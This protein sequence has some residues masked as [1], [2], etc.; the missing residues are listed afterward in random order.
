[1]FIVEAEVRHVLVDACIGSICILILVFSLVPSRRDDLEA[2]ALMFIHLLTPHGLP[3]TRNG[4]PRTDSEHNRLKSA[5][6]S[7]TPEDLCRN[8]PS[9]FEDF[10]RYCRQLQFSEQ[11]D[12]ERWR[13]EFRDLA[14]ENKFPDSDDFIW[15]PPAPT[16]KAPV[17]SQVRVQL[18]FIQMSGNILHLAI[19]T[20]YQGAKDRRGCSKGPQRSC[21]DAD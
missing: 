16:S 11:P 17:K 10:L 7:A 3:W 12:Y 5:K 2:A 4:V 1:V 21:R 20:Y 6:Q 14:V 15:P 19:I 13:E 8:I 18:F 9:A